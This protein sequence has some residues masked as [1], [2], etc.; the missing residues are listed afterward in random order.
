M[1]S[2]ENFGR[3]VG[4]GDQGNE[5]GQASGKPVFCA[6]NECFHMKK[7]SALDAPQRVRSK[8]LRTGSPL[9]PKGE[10]GYRSTLD[11]ADFR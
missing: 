1:I 4:G 2:L 11:T 6:T 5:E 9:R 10:S 7:D 8:M 3:S